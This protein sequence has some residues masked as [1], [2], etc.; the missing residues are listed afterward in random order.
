MKKYKFTIFTF[1]FSAVF[2]YLCASV[3]YDTFLISDWTRP[4]KYVYSICTLLITV[5]GLLVDILKH[6]QNDL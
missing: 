5:L 4:E 1:V 6:N 2:L 3:G